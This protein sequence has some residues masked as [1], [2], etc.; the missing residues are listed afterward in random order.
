MESDEEIERAKPSEIDLVNKVIHLTSSIDLRHGDK[1][2]HRD[3][4]ELYI[5]FNG[6]KP[7]MCYLD[8]DGK[9]RHYGELTEYYMGDYS[10]LDRPIEELDQDVLDIITGKKNIEDFGMESEESNELEESTQL[11]HLKSA[12]SLVKAKNEM[13]SQRNYVKALHHRLHGML[14]RKA[15]KLYAIMEA[16][17][18]KLEKV[19]KI[20]YTIELY[21]GVHE[22]VVQLVEG[23]KASTEQPICFRQQILFMDEEV[24]IYDNNGVDF[25]NIKKFDDWISNHF[26]KIMPEEKGVVVFRIRR[27]KKDYGGSIENAIFQDEDMKTYFLIRN[28]NNLYRIWA[29]LTVDP[30]L[31]PLKNEIN[32]IYEKI[33][34]QEHFKSYDQKKAD[35]LVLQY[36]RNSLVLQGIIDR[37]DIFSPI[38]EGINIFN[39][40]SYGNTIKLIYDEENILPSGRKPFK[41]WRKEINSQIERGSRILY[42]YDWSAMKKEYLDERFFGYRRYLPDAPRDCMFT[43]EDI[44]K[45]KDYRKKEYDVIKVLFFAGKTYDFEDPKKRTAFKLY[46]DDWFILNY[47]KISLEDLDFYIH[48]RTDRQNYLEMLPVLIEAKKTRLKELEWEKAFVRMTVEDMFRDGVKVDEAQVWEAVNW[49]KNKVIWKRP[50]TKDDSKALRMIKSKL[51]NAILH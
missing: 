45:E 37:T 43:V 35:S 19:Y 3:G 15:R 41:E 16:F 6:E 46:P 10:K 50:I 22:D 32:K 26:K 39:P 8:D 12:D 28:G 25:R 13:E 23:S 2:I 49:W 30:R 1:I 29:P 27:N 9:E 17:S 18:E 21:L 42:H 5:N 48:S 33:K 7:Q 20:L 36:Q 38:P 40:D 24:G 44:L 47:D 31:F 14:D 51:K 34:E 4:F 11:V